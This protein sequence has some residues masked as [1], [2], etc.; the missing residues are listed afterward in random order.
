GAYSD[1]WAIAPDARGLAYEPTS[2]GRTNIWL[3][4]LAGG[5][6]RQFTREYNA[7]YFPVWSPDGRRIAFSSTRKGHQDLFVKLVDEPGSEDLLL[8]TDQ[9]KIPT[10]WSPDGK[11]LL[12][13]NY[14]LKTAYDI[15]ALPLGANAHPG[16][17]FAVVQ[18][19]DEERDGQFSSD[20][21]WIAYQ[22]NT[23]GSFEIYVEPFQGQAG[24]SPARWKVSTNG[25]TQARWGQ[26]GQEL[27]YVAGDG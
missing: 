5:S 24:Q 1:A 17:P 23:S 20:G 6:V 18:T 13:R 9:N 4:E 12:Y 26:D 11:F 2:T 19:K 3:L 25:G 15:W 7:D 22:S 16:R 8:A 14:D 27:F 10:D 21:K